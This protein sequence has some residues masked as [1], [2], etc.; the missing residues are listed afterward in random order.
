MMTDLGKMK[1][2][3]QKICILNK[4]ELM[5]CSLPAGERVLFAQFAILGDLPV[6][7]EQSEAESFV[8]MT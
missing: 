3:V 6:R 8:D 1:C 5:I 2:I 7:G 4:K